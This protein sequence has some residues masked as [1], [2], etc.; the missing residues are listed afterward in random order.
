M[1]SRALQLVIVIA[2]GVALGLLLTRNWRA[3]EPAAA[4]PAPTAEPHP[5]AVA[6]A[7]STTAKKAD[8]D[9]PPPPVRQFKLPAMRPPAPEPGPVAAAN[10][11][12]PPAEATV[13]VPKFWQ[14][15]G[16]APESYE[17]LSDREQVKS[18]GASVLIRSKRKDIAVTL[19]GSILQTVFASSLVG[20]RLEVSAFVRA[21][22]VRAQTVALS[23]RALD[24]DNLLVASANS[25]AEFPKIGPQWTRVSFVVDVPWSAAQVSY[26]LVLAGKGCVWIDD[27]RLTS[28]D[29]T[30]VA[31]TSTAPPRQ[32]G[33]PVET[34]KQ[35]L[36][37]P[38]NLDFEE[39][40]D[41]SAPPREAG[42][43]STI[44][45]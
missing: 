18:G 33:Q 35:A 37:Q 24:P 16:S 2:L 26:G 40:T 28:V 15:R 36:H 45:E 8:A 20:K 19:N 29:R 7:A 11:E 32:L 14:L 4:V 30:V 44:R 5:A 31:P 38:E 17:L 12:P 34:V 23:F 43:L 6:P 42:N 10:K 39:T 21:E 3:T 22:D 13:R 41:V 25:R 9:V 27:F 1:R